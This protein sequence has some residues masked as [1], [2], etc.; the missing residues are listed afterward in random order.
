MFAAKAWGPQRLYNLFNNVGING[1][2]AAVAADVGVKTI[3][4]LKG[5]RI[6]WIKA[7]PGNN[8]NMTAFLAFGGLTWD[9]VEKVEVPGVQQSLD[10][11]LNDQVD[12]AW[13][14]TLTGTLNQIAASPR[15]LYYPPMPKDDTAGWERA[16]AIAPWFAPVLVQSFIK[17]TGVEEPFE[18]MNYPY[19][20]FVAS[21]DIDDAVAYGLTAAILGNFDAIK[22]AGP[23]ME[24]YAIDRQL[25]SYVFPYHPQSIAY[26]KEQ[27]LWTEDDE[28]RN[29]ELLR[30]QDI[31]AAA[32][33]K[34][35]GMNVAEAD[36]EA[37]WMKLRAASL[38]DAG[39][40]V[41]FEADASN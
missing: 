2:T 21:P 41:V 5:K 27:G 19:P 25:L 34:M 28:Q 4:D 6:A 17:A 30:R 37:E 16:H 31:L 36:F 3:A 35:S 7:S 20:L 22:E 15:G 1:Q 12:A 24:G 9:D 13:A 29:A 11:I 32:W 33:E 10:A 18:G 40:H 26:F 14:S 23:S 39:L 38:T 8:M